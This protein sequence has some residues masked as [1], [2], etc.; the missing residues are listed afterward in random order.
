MAIFSSANLWA[1]RVTRGSVGYVRLRINAPHVEILVISAPLP[2]SALGSWDKLLCLPGQSLYMNKIVQ[3]DCHMV[4]KSKDSKSQAIPAVRVEGAESLS[5]HV[6][7]N[8]ISISPGQCVRVE[9]VEV[10]CR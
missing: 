2:L 7:K 3:S 4:L 5:T 1:M 10:S 6:P 8:L 9:T